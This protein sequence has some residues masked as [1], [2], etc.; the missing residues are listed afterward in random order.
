MEPAQLRLVR[1]SPAPEPSPKG[2][3]LQDAPS[4]HDPVCLRETLFQPLIVIH[5][6]NIAVITY[7]IPADVRCCG[8]CPK[9]RCIFIEILLYSRMDDQLFRRILVIDLHQSSKLRRI[10]HAKPCLERDP[11]GA[12]VKDLSQEPVQ[13]LRISEKSGAPPL[14]HHSL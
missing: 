13:A 12:S 14:C 8:K 5:G 1:S 4:R 6:E 2:R 9:I 11:D 7:R 10:F 3:D